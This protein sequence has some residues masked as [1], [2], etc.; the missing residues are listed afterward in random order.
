MGA[1]TIPISLLLHAVLRDAG[2]RPGRLTKDA[3]N[4]LRPFDAEGEP[5]EALGVTCFKGNTN[6][7]GLLGIVRVYWVFTGTQIDHS[8]AKT[9][10]RVQPLIVRP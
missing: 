1:S 10:N 6:P 5:C 8:A 2:P 7:D 9:G 3:H 4:E